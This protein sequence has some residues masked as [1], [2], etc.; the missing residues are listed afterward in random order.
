MRKNVIC[1]MAVMLSA[2]SFLTGCGSS[3]VAANMELAQTSVSAITVPEDVLVVGLGESSHGVKEYQEMKAEVFQALVENNGCRT[4]VIE[5]D[6]GSALKVD[7]YIHGGEGT[8]KEAAAQIGFRIYRTEEMANLIQWM[9]TYNETAAEGE[10]L[11]FY[12]MDMQ[13]ADNSKSY[14]FHILEQINPDISAKY[15]EALAFL[16][17]D[18]MFDISADAFEHG[19]LVAEKLIQEV[20]NSGER[21][22]EIFGNEAYAYARECARSIYNCCDIRKS[23]SAYNAVRDRHMAEKIQWYVER[24]DG[25]VI[26]ING[27]NGHI[28]KVNATPYYDCLGKL[29][30]EKLGNGY[31]AIG[32]DA[33]VTVFNS[34]TNGGFEELKVKNQ[35]SLNALV[36]GIAQNYYYIDF[37]AA[38]EDDNWNKIISDK[39]R[40]TALN[41]TG[42]T[43]MKVF[44]TTE[45]IP[46]DTFDSM[47]VFGKVSPTTLEQ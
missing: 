12:G 46:K 9:R 22:V 23:D 16:N 32:T 24:G 4:F 30:A 15:R 37:S 34:Q 38:A 20:D 40:I 31:Y 18:A 35:N 1:I 39:Q 14:V 13:Q 44:Y 5:G 42:A 47:I 28:G 26:F 8:A 11:H 10:D 25:S 19:M 21:I 6:F 2:V 45:V 43:M 29:L 7:D 41:V 33:E 27:H 36:S 17:D 3:T